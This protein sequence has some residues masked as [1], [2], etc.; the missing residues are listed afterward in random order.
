MQNSVSGGMAN[1][2]IHGMSISPTM[3]SYRC[4]KGRCERKKAHNYHR[5]GGRGI[6]FR[7]RDFVHFLSVVGLRPAGMTL[8]RIDNNGHY[9]DGNVRWATAKAQANNRTCSY[10]YWRYIG[11]EC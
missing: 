10:N 8:E 6:E 9:E 5:Y 4:A 2:R 3:N 11:G 7:F 1:H